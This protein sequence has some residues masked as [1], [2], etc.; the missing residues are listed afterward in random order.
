MY[1]SRTQPRK[2]NSLNTS[3]AEKN[4]DGSLLFSRSRP[5][6]SSTFPAFRFTSFNP[7]IFQSIVLGP[8]SNPCFS[9][10]TSATPLPG[11]TVFKSSTTGE[12]IAII[13]WQKHPLVEIQDVMFKQPVSKWLE[14]SPD[15]S[16]RRMTY[17]GSKFIWEPC[18]E[19]ICLYAPGTSEDHL[20]GRISR[21]QK[22]VTLELTPET[23]ETGFLT[24]CAVATF[25]LQSG[26]S[27]D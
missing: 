2:H 18:G 3:S 6:S 5:A 24:T 21:D 7:N 27:I 20:I 26:R 9:I 4:T 8:Q 16:H 11:Y 17:G 12:N 14:L 23:V 13:E 1:S 25:L 15:M 19:F 22:T 10:A